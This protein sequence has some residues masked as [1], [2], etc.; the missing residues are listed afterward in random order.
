MLNVSLY[1]A[2]QSVAYLFN[3]HEHELSLQMN[4]K[5]FQTYVYLITIE[6]YQQ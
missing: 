3:K 6:F 5:E 2:V 1:C 4:L